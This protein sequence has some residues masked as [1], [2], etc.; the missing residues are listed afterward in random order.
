ML[1][2]IFAGTG[3][4]PYVVSLLGKHHGIKETAIRL[5]HSSML[6]QTEGQSS[7]TVG[8]CAWQIFT[9]ETVNS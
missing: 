9:P 6:L 2:E 5:I 3:L 1:Q 8:L 4:S 7:A